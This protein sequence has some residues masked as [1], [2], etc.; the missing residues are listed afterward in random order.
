MVAKRLVVIGASAGGIDAI[1]TIIAGIPETLPAAVCIVLHMS[2]TS[3]GLLPEILDRA[4]LVRVTTAF[5]GQ[6]LEAGR[7]YL[8]APDR[9][10]L[11]EPGKLRVTK[12][13]REHRFRPAIDP[14]FRSAA[15]VF[16]PNAIG[17][18]LT[19][20][21]DD[22]TAGLWTIKRLGGIAVVQDPSDAL[23]ASMPLSAVRNVDVDYVVPVS[24]IPSLL[25]ELTSEPER[26]AEPV[27][28]V[29]PEVDVE[30]K[31]AKEEDPQAVGLEKI[32]KPSPYA[33]P[34]CSG[35]LLSIDEG[36]L[37]RF[38]CH[39]GHAYSTDSLLTAM[40][41]GVDEAMGIA[42]R[43]L[44][45][46]MLLTRAV[47]AQLKQHNHIDASRRMLEASDRAKRRG[48]AIRELILERDTVP[49]S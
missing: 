48:E 13:P 15:Q 12:G 22:G 21:L 27:A 16:G 34:D 29:P 30:I 43:A 35:V 40:S 37:I 6:R 44:E 7:V 23:Y 4:G 47:A 20:S 26:A 11:V 1:R 24:R 18:I 2:P 25:A 38:R 3:P 45:E 39:T 9:H 5:D 42:V 41:E 10:L 49:H 17:V 19:G 36:G 46:A 31:I 32:G 28:A 33:C 8:A 14:L